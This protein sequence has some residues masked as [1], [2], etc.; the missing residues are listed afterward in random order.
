MTG[1]VDASQ[2]KPFNPE[3]Y[4]H[5]LLLL[6]S[7]HC[8]RPVLHQGL[9]QFVRCVSANASGCDIVMTVYLAGIKDGIDSSE[10]QIQPS[11]SVTDQEKS[12]VQSL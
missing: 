7:L 12:D 6:K 8:G 5:Q 2:D 9:N 3:T 4:R 10:I 11:P 1:P